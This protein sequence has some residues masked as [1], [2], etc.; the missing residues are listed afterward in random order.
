MPVRSR[1]ASSLP[2]FASRPPSPAGD[3]ATHHLDIEVWHPQRLS[4]HRPYQGKGVRHHVSVPAVTPQAI[5]QF[6]GRGPD[7]LRCPVRHTRGDGPSRPVRTAAAASA[8]P[9]PDGSGCR[10]PARRDARNVPGVVHA[11][12]GTPPEA[13]CWIARMLDIKLRQKEAAQVAIPAL[14]EWFPAVVKT[15]V[16]TPSDIDHPSVRRQV[17]V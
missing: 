5:T 4:G 10:L 1:S 11:A 15:H 6:V 16:D 2:R 13:R 17:Q 9:A 12:R 8:A 3:P 14:H 7:G